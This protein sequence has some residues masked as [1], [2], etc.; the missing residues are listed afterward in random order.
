M[1]VADL[2][3]ATQNVSDIG[4]EDTTILMALVNNHVS[5]VAEK[6]PPVAIVILEHR[7]MQHIGVCEY[8]LR[9]ISNQTACFAWSSS[10]IAA[11]KVRS[12]LDE[13][14]NRRN[15]RSEFTQL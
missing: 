8:D 6:I 9:L 13:S 1:Y 3:K 11:D 15:C 10:V 4:P 12:L 7:V 5:Q 14:S 2:T